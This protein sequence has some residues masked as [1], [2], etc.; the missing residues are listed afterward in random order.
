MEKVK[1]K[2]GVDVFEESVNLFLQNDWEISSQSSSNAKLQKSKLGMP[3]WL[4]VLIMI[5][6][7]LI[8]MIFVMIVK[9]IAGKETVTLS[10]L[11]PDE[12]RVTGKKVS[13][14]TSNPFDLINV[15]E[16]AGGLSWA[17]ILGIGLV[18][19]FVNGLILSSI[20]V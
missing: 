13:T 16:N 18:S 10:M 20:A 14:T 3:T 6:F 11:N 15:A 1:R 12:V 8:G 7:A 9:A 19:A 4:A 17:A 2:R 5:Y